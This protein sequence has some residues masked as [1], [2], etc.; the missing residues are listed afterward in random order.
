MEVREGT[1]RG[2]NEKEERVRNTMKGRG[3]EEA[4]NKGL[5]D[6]LDDSSKQRMLKRLTVFIYGV[7][8]T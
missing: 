6:I 5:S 2:R 8:C 1:K 3:N 7:L 4:Y